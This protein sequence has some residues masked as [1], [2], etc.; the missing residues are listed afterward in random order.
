MGALVNGQW[1][2]NP[3]F[4]IDE[5]GEFIRKPTTFHETICDNHKIYQPESQRY[6]L[7]VS[8]ACPW[9]HR[10][11]IMR[12]L[13]SLNNHISISVV[14]P[15]MLNKGW[16]FSTQHPGTT[17][18][19]LYQYDY[20]YQLYQQSE[21]NITTRV[22]V[23]ILWDKKTKTIVNNES[24]EIIRIFNTQFNKLTGNEHDYYPKKHV[25]SID[26]WNQSIYSNINNGVYAAG[27]ATS[28]TAYEQAIARLY[29]Q[30]QQCDAILQRQDFLC[31]DDLTEAD[32]RLLPTLLRFDT[33]YHTHFKC[34]IKRIIDYP[35][36]FAYL[37]RCRKIPA[38]QETTHDWHIKRHY[39]FSH[40]HINPYQI[41]PVSPEVF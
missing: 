2:E 31:G 37:N 1:Q 7:Y 9:A 5:H 4:P 21:Q 26:Q 16:T 6:H 22:T 11:L 15:D 14:C 27:F 18:D 12:A 20:L 17:G 23:P 30:L 3:E 34:T 39:Y 36:L 40:Q 29:T 38:I 19:Q 8:Y 41:I 28:Q 25:K 35:G 33:V 32:I 24:S 13:K 10:T